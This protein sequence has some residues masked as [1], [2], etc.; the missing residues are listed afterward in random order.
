MLK[1]ITKYDNTDDLLESSRHKAQQTKLV[2][3]GDLVVQTGS[4]KAG[5]TGSNLL[6][7]ETI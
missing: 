3:K 4:V 2:K 5:G 7:V 6:V 1:F